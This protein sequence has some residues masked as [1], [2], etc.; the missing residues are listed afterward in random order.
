[1]NKPN[2]REMA[3]HIGLLEYLVT[4]L[5]DDKRPEIPDLQKQSSSLLSTGFKYVKV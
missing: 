5:L 3:R 4:D 1:M 2:P